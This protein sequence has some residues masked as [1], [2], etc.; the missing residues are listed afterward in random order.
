MYVAK[1][2]IS[3]PN[4][5]VLFSTE[6]FIIHLTINSVQKKKGRL[7]IFAVIWRGDQEIMKS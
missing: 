5:F 7:I 3:R 4:F 1:T 2:R 6:F